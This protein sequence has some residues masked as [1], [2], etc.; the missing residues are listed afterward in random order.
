MKH[1]AQELAE[2]TKTCSDPACEL[3]TQPLEAFS[4][5]KNTKDGLNGM[6]RECRSRK[7]SK[8]GKRNKPKPSKPGHA[9]CGNTECHQREQPIE[10]FGKDSRSPSGLRSTCKECRKIEAKKYLSDPEVRARHNETCVKYYYANRE[11][12]LEHAKQNRAYIT[13]R[14]RLWFQN[15]EHARE[16]RKEWGFK[17]RG[18]RRAAKLGLGNEKVERFALLERDKTCYLCGIEFVEGDV[19]EADH[20]VP[21]ARTELSPSHT[22]GNVAMTHR[23]CNRRKL[24]RTPT[25]YWAKQYGHLARDH[26]Y[27]LYEEEND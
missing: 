19:L 13:E 26:R 22:Y 14:T 8:T 9:V 21:L 5:N 16:L 6:C 10:N 24:N 25:E 18:V 7:R 2:Q 15:N 23:L 1:E 11:A 20:K 27:D 12:R 4:K 17:A 3:G